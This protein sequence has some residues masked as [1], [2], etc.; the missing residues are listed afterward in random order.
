MFDQMSRL[1]KLHISRLCLLGDAEGSPA[2]NRTVVG[3][4]EEA[5]IIFNHSLELLPRLIQ[6]YLNWAVLV[7]ERAILRRLEVVFEALIRQLCSI[8]I[9]LLQICRT[10]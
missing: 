1:P 2:R 9:I 8:I 7:D 4:S 6:I 10:P 5:G 3:L